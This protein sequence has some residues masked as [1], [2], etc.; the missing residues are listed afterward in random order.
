MSSE[1][2][3]G[4]ENLAVRVTGRLAAIAAANGLSMSADMS[5]GTVTI[6]MSPLVLDDRVVSLVT[7]RT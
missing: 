5:A 7:G 2:Q 1:E 3:S 6:D 4:G